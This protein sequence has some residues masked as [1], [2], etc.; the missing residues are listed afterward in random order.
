MAWFLLVEE[1][2]TDRALLSGSSMIARKT[3]VAPHFRPAWCFQSIKF[4]GVSNSVVNGIN[5]INSKFLHFHITYS[6]S[7]TAYNLKITAPGDSPNT[8]GMHISETNGVNVSKSTIGTGDD[9]ISIGAGVTD[10][11]FSEIT[12]GP[13]HGI[14]VG[15]LGKYQNEKDVN[16]IMV[17]NCTLSKTNNGVRI[18]SWPG[19]PPSA[20]SSITFQDII[21]DSVENPILI[22]QNYGSHSS[23]PSRVKISDVHY[24]N[25]GG[26]S[27]SNVAVSLTSSSSN[28]CQGIELA[29][30]DLTYAGTNG[31][32]FNHISF[33]FE[34]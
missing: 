29:D 13:G 30:I 24:K 14:S 2:L 8:D 31:K 18:K 1:P 17:T 23:E 7:F 22:D 33:I 27:A 5:S 16:G 19:S 20:A 9:C 15:S 26:T 10:A 28:P 4:Q 11:T 34:C 25:I 12:C 32:R 6:S 3:A 21:M